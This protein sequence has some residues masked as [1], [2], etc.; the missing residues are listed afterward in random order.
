MPL[1]L[2]A[3][4]LTTTDE[5]IPQPA[6]VLIGVTPIPRSLQSQVSNTTSY[7]L[8]LQ[9]PHQAL[10]QLSSTTTLDNMQARETKPSQGNPAVPSASLFRLDGRS[11]ISTSGCQHSLT[12]P[13][14][15]NSNRRHRLPRPDSRRIRP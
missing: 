15:R 8:H 6:A 11:I 4:R 13:L 2:Q 7:L 12:A 1:Y 14:I 10:H 9:H 3:E 5:A